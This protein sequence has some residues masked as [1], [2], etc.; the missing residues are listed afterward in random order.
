MDGEHDERGAA[1]GFT[2]DQRSGLHARQ[3]D[4]DRTLVAMH[5]LEAALAEAAPLREGPWRDAVVEALGVLEA[6]T[7]EELANAER[8]DSLL[9]DLSR[10]QPRMR[11]RARA[12]RLQYAQLRDAIG[13][14]G[15]ELE[16]RG[17]DGIDFA[18]IRQRLAWVLAALR[19]QRARESDLIYEAYYDAF[20]AE[21]RRG[22]PG[23]EA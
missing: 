11:N 19:H 17:E 13:D 7:A 20:R 9:A 15:R 10:H 8:P 4:H 14:L 6:A 12:L 23:A 3:A 18:D 16:E 2:A 1:T 22:E 21:L 5:R